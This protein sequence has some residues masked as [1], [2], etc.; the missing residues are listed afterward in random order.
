MIFIYFFFKCFCWRPNASDIGDVVALGL[1]NGE[2]LMKIISEDSVSQY[3]TQ[4]VNSK[5][6]NHKQTKSNLP[7]THPCTSLSW[8]HKN[9]NQIAA[10]FEKFDR[11]N[12]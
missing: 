9:P 7:L 2:I 3:F 1:E 10:G 4:S 11:S 12:K 5:S 6:T 8:N